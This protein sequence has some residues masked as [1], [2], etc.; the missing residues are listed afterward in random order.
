MGRKN[1][2]LIYFLD[3]HFQDLLI[4]VNHKK[5][6]YGF[7]LVELLVVIAIIGILIA[8][9]LPAVQAARE[10]ARRMQ[11][12]NN[13]KQMGLAMHNHVTAQGKLP[14]A[15]L[16][17]NGSLSCWRGMSALVQILPYMENSTI[18]AQVNFD[19]R[20][21]SQASSGVWKNSMP[22][23]CCPSDDAH[24]RVAWNIMARSNVAFCVGTGGSF[25]SG[26]P[27]VIE[28]VIPPNRTGVVLETDGAFYLEEG[29]SL[30]DF[31]DG[32]SVTAFGS[33]ILAGR[34]DT[35]A[36]VYNIDYRGR[37]ALPYEGGAAYAHRTTPNSSEPDVM[38]YCCVSSDDMPC[39]VSGTHQD[40]YYAARSR[41]PGGVNVL[42][43]DGHVQFYG[44][45]VD[46]EIWRSLATIRGGET[47]GQE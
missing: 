14:C 27:D 12:G 13:L 10:A 25:A 39:V 1:N 4:M 15:G 46:S 18:T 23:Y 5:I 42:F 35:A 17:W 43:G 47:P 45:E 31:T 2:R 30:N 40:E 34:V 37:W 28:H 8:M 44:N 33:E 32:L 38:P 26:S 19:E 22:M 21:W 20:L 41:H 3:V 7:T 16:G 6:P 24:D 9:L 36:S 11:C 29:R